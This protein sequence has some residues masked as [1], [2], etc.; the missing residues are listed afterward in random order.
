MKLH[1]Q[2]LPQERHFYISSSATQPKIK[3]IDRPREISNHQ[4]RIDSNFP[5]FLLLLSYVDKKNICKSF[6]AY[7]TGTEVRGWE[8]GGDASK[9]CDSEA[10]LLV[11]A[12]ISG[13]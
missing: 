5:V 6:A 8:D 11:K 12:K 3:I 7:L 9:I 13:R 10:Q 1:F 2:R 4:V